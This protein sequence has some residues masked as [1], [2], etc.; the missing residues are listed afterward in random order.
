MLS[1]E[2]DFRVYITTI[3]KSNAKRKWLR[4]RPL[5]TVAL[6]QLDRHFEHIECP[7][8][9]IIYQQKALKMNTMGWPMYGNF[10]KNNFV[11]ILL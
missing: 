5:I 2:S 1:R 3:T 10:P 7:I 8:T 4:F 11:Y 6:K 9:M